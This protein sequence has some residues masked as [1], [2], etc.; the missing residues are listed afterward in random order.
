MGIIGNTNLGDHRWN[1]EVMAYGNSYT[2]TEDGIFV[3]VSAFLHHESY[4]QFFHSHIVTMAI[5]D[6]TTGNLI[7][8]CQP[9]SVSAEASFNEVITLPL[10]AEA[11][12][13]KGHRYLVMVAAERMG[14]RFGCWAE[15]HTGQPPEDFPHF[16]ILWDS[17]D[18]LVWNIATQGFPAKYG[19]GA[20]WGRLTD[21]SVKFDIYATF[22]LESE[23][24]PPPPPP[25]LRSVW[26]LPYLGGSSDPPK[27]LYT[28]YDGD[29]VLITAI[30]GPGMMVKEW[31]V[32][33]AIV[34]T[35]DPYHYWLTVYGDTDIKIFFIEGTAPPP[36]PP[37]PQPPET[38]LINI[39]AGPGGSTNPPPGQYTV[40]T[41]KFF[42]V[43]AI[44]SSGMMVKEWRV[45]GEKLPPYPSI[46]VEITENTTIE[47]YFS[48]SFPWLIIGE[49]AVGSA[50]V[51]R[52]G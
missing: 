18:Q 28:Y 7:A 20:S 9:L 16:F 5:L 35:P 2:A 26:I 19:Q 50:L 17:D 33:D 48:T 31:R 38:M 1:I 52:S 36:P 13:I 45:N 11:P 40:T 43:S 34:E 21:Y 42:N 12:M 41:G 30:P 51:T 23:P 15:H 27:G 25:Q 10:R 47:V 46:N 49:L 6:L 39:V 8:D 24:P 3:S 29:Q 32:N 44:P 4:G 14:D 22:R 37:P